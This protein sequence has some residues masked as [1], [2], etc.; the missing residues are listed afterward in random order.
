[1]LSVFKS[2]LLGI[3]VCASLQV[4]AQIF[5]K[6]DNAEDLYNNAIKE[7]KLGHYDK[8][9]TLVNQGL[10]K[11]PDDLD[12][13]LLL[14]RLYMLTG[15]YEAA[16]K[17]VKMV[18]TKN[19]DYRDAYLYAINIE[20]ATHKY[21]EADCYADEA[22]GYYRNDRDFML[23]KL[24]I[25]NLLSKIY[26]GNLF[27][28]NMLSRF[29]DDTTVQKAYIEHN[30][31]SGRY[32]A[33]NGNAQQAS[34]SFN[35][36][37]A[38]SPNNPEAKNALLSLY[39]QGQNFESALSQ[40]NEGLIANPRSYE[41]LLRKLDIL[42]NMHAYADA[43]VQLQT[44][45]KYYPNDAKIRGM[46]TEL[47]LEAAAY[48][49]NTD[50]YLLYRAILEKNPGNQEALNKVI[51]FSMSRGAYKEAL[52]WINRGL[53]SNPNDPKL[54]SL[55]LDILEEDHKYSA[56]A[57]LAEKLWQRSPS[58]DLKARVVAL[59]IASGREYMR[60][61][62]YNLA[63]IAF[64]KALAIAPDNREALDNLVNNYIAQK[65]NAQALLVLNKAL[66]YYPA[67]DLLLLKKSSILADLGRYEEAAVITA[68]LARKHPDDPRFA[69]TFTEQRLTAGRLFMQAEEYDLAKE[70]YIQVLQ[71]DPKNVDA[72]NYMI[73]LESATGQLDSAIMYADQALQYNPGNRDLLLKKA[74]VLDNLKRY[75]ESAAI[76]QQLMLRYPYTP[77]YKTAYISSLLAAGSVYQQNN[78]TD[79]ALSIYESILT[80]SPKDSLALQY[81]T[82][83]LIG[84]K[85]YDSAL[86]YVNQGIQYYPDNTTLLMKRATILENQRQYAAASLAADSL[87]KLNASP[88]N[89]DYADYLKSKTLKNQFGLFFLHSS[90]DYVNDPYNIATVEYRRFIKRGSYAGRIN[91]AGRKDGTGLQAEG[92]L[93]Y[94]HGPKLYSYAVV[95]YSNELVFP[96]LRAGYSIFKSFKHDIEAELGIRYL[97][98]DSSNSISGVASIA[99]TF[100][101]FWI[102][103]RGYFISDAP[104]FYTA[105]N[106]TTRYYMNRHQD[107][108]SLVVGLGTSP[109][110]KSRLIQFPQLQGLLTRSIGTGYQHV[111]K[112]RTTIGIN[113]TWITQKVSNQ[114]YHNQYDLYLTFL[115]KF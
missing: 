74:G 69:A 108:I 80:I 78:A 10:K 17:Q 46:E 23:K 1:M 41:L 9:I 20:L 29:P 21:E 72:L 95:A 90:F 61:Q 89:V 88:V 104:N 102:N 106:L 112:Y 30:L 34:I 47:R 52:E 4:Q 35:K 99:K 11:Q 49:T 28:D 55:K 73:N 101:E 100:D 87:V 40:V 76:M 59:N 103:L 77:K 43:L 70:Q 8:A 25:Q 15:N 48:Y 81:T 110:D 24:E 45:L 14:G 67:D 5:S 94:T 98:A 58:A 107:Y 42:R 60:D 84:A 7:T 66:T 92:E 114:T 2:I 38:I 57:T 51:G 13:A 31:F 71:Q 22:L 12:M 54:L 39:L 79:S 109:D 56:A 36:V 26:E 63:T 85:R 115:R 97:E 53:K 6:K 27:A 62:Q 93:Y 33:K 86:V 83:L 82:N 113:G 64:E 18:L 96:K 3:C 32:Y 105:Y 65:D 91:Y 75:Q 44:I 68:A 50:P 19:P 16:R 111:F 37:L